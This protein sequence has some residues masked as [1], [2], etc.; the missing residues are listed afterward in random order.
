MPPPRAA[1]PVGGDRA[2]RRRRPRPPVGLMV[3]QRRDLGA[4][5]HRRDPPVHAQ[6]IGLR[7]EPSSLEELLEAR[8]LREEARRRLGADPAGARDLVRRISAE[9]DEVGNLLRLDAVALADLR[10]ADPRELADPAHRLQ[11]RDVVRHELESVA[12]GRRD[13]GGAAACALR[14]DRR[15]QEV[16]GLVARCLAADD[17]GGLEQGRGEIELLEQ[18]GVED[19]SRL[20]SGQQ[21]VPVRR[22][23]QRVPSDEDRTRPLRLPEPQQHRRDTGEEV[24]R[25]TV[26]AADRARQRMERAVGER[27]AVDD[28]QRH[29][30]AIAPSGGAEPTACSSA[31]IDSRR[32]SVAICA[33]SAS[34]RATRS[35]ISIGVP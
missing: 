26:L 2:P 6:C 24:A 30:H 29:G 13:Q 32:R 12:V 15:S 5:V 3:G 23:G 22:D 1:Q 7:R 35:P 28:E 11:D 4:G 20:V 14:G 27:V 19:T 25:P 34:S 17:S 31:V 10:G 21:L 8:V 33:A 18:R 9:C 16:V